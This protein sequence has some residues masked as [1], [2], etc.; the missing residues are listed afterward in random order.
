MTVYDVPVARLQLVMEGPANPHKALNCPAEV[1]ALVA[2]YLAGADREHFVAVL[3]DAKNHVLCITTVSIGTLSSALVHPREL[4]KAAILANAASVIVAH[5]HPSGDPT[6]SAEDLALTKR[7]TEAGQL[8]GIPILDSVT[9][10]CA[11]RYHS[12]KEAGLLA[13]GRWAA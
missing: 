11:G 1:A 13:S 3:L 4:Y 5:N 12:A 9:I 2:D 6:P 8:L 10:G 7:L